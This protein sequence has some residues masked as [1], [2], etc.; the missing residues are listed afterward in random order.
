MN[1]NFK[2]RLKG[3]KN[4]LNISSILRI[5][6]DDLKDIFMIKDKELKYVDNKAYF[7]ALVI[8]GNY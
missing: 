3:H 7:G 1:S 2:L 5:L 4:S 6:G 8:F